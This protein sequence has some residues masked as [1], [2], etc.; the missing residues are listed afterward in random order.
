MANENHLDFGYHWVWSYGHLIPASLFAAA[1]GAVIIGGAPDYFALVLAFFAAWA[2]VGFVLARF[3]VR[4]NEPMQLPEAV[5]LGTGETRILDIGCGSGRT[6]IMAGTAYP[7]ARIVALDNFSASYIRG[8]GKE[9]T[10]R[11]FRV[12]GMGE[13]AQVQEGDMRS[14]PFEAEEFDAAV[15]SYAIDHMTRD[16][17]PGVLAEVNRVLRPDG[18]FLLM[19]IVPN[20]WGVITYGPFLHMHFLGRS[21]WPRALA[22]AGFTIDAEGAGPGSWFLARKTGV[23]AKADEARSEAPQGLTLHG[24]SVPKA[25]K[26]MAVCGVGLLALA[27]LLRLLGLAVSWWWIAAAIPVGMHGGLILVV[28]AGAFRWILSASTSKT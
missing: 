6:S 20:L 26:A 1:A 2:L 17:I 7:E 23:P 11:N 27:L 25:I 14:M 8:H 4:M 28:L 18:R 24:V 13:R 21:F 5:N 9:N 12:A 19:V 10:L 3:V 16:E 22:Q 15:S